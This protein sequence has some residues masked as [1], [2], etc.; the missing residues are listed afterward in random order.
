MLNAL[1]ALSVIHTIFFMSGIEYLFIFAFHFALQQYPL[2]FTYV[3]ILMT[4][5]LTVYLYVFV[6]MLITTDQNVE[7]D[8]ME[9]PGKKKQAT[10]TDKSEKFVNAVNPEIDQ[11]FDVL[12]V[13]ITNFVFSFCSIVLFVFFIQQLLILIICLL[14]ERDDQCVH[15]WGV[16]SSKF[17]FIFFVIVMQAFKSHNIWMLSVQYK[18]KNNIQH[19]VRHMNILI[20]VSIF[21]ITYFTYIQHVER[22]CNNVDKI[23]SVIQD[24]IFLFFSVIFYIFCTFFSSDEP[25]HISNVFSR[26]SQFFIY[27]IIILSIFITLVTNIEIHYIFFVFYSLLVLFLIYSMW[28]DMRKEIK[29]D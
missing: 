5:I 14:D 29:N 23:P 12:V 26:Y 21:N 27:V 1:N 24:Y 17:L 18:K 15:I 9:E 10:D 25:G 16:S 13:A 7:T 3:Q 4:L 19:N 22:L 11:S 8:I 28:S 20:F 6:L 2:A